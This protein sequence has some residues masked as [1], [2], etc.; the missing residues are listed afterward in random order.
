MNECNVVNYNYYVLC[1][2]SIKGKETP[3]INIQSPSSTTVYLVVILLFYFVNN[4]IL[5][6][7]GLGS[8]KNKNESSR[9]KRKN[10]V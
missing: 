5:A 4:E 6:A 7:V 9:V 1:T 10:P 2:K 3:I 8:A